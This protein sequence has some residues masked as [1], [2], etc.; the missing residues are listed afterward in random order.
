MDE[1]ENE[2]DEDD[3]DIILPRLYWIRV[4]FAFNF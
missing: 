3:E 4:Y 2:K 1:N